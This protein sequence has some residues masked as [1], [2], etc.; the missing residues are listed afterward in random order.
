MIA[1]VSLAVGLGGLGASRAIRE[2]MARPTDPHVDW[3][4][5][6]AGILPAWLVALLGLLGPSP[7]PDVTFVT[8]LTLLG[9]IAGGLAGAITTEA[10][11][12]ADAESGRATR[13]GAWRLGT[14][15]LTP[16]WLIA[17]G[18]ALLR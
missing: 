2:R 9:T 4:L 14:L 17:M 15:A 11:I 13:E 12:R 1:L 3:A 10:R 7:R 5:G 16:A 6:L 18:G 8:A